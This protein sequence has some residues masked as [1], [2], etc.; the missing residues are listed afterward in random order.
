MTGFDPRVPLSMESPNESF[1]S[2]TE[3]FTT[4]VRI[5]FA[6][7]QNGFAPVEKEIREILA[8]ALMKVQANGGTVEQA[9]PELLNLDDTYRVLRGMHYGAVNARFPLEVQKHFKKTLRD[10]V[11]SGV[12]LSSD[13]IY[14]AM[15]D[16]T[17]L[18]HTM[19]EFLQGYDVL[20]IPV[21]GLEPGRVEEEFPTV[22]DGNPVTDYVDWL[23]FSFL[24][25]TTALPAISVPV[26]FTQL[27]MPVGIQL[28][29]PPR[30][31]ALHLQV[32]R[33]VEL[34]VDFPRTPIDP[35]IKHSTI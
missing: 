2:A 20:A 9:C 27:G 11:R 24:A 6:P 26:G 10:N 5:A 19:R 12:E 4:K 14:S 18:Y 34:A 30:G 21:V 16:R 22:V 28:I 13:S 25:T 29:G 23:R 8:N 17:T 31:D 35:V 33:A 7:D 3:R 15:R 32:A 1:Q